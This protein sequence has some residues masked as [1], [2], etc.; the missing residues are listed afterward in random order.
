MSATG[1]FFAIIAVIIIICGGIG[2]QSANAGLPVPDGD[3]RPCMKDQATALRER[4]LPPLYAVRWQRGCQCVLEHV[5]ALFALFRKE[6][7]N[8]LH[9]FVLILFD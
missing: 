1:N 5:R 7:L 2:C 3:R 9:F 6:K 4:E 8:L